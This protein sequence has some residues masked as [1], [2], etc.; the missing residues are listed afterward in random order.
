MRKLVIL[1]GNGMLGREL[2]ALS[3][4][5]GFDVKTFD[6]PTFDISNPSAI[7]D[8]IKGAD[9]IVNCAAYTAVDKAESEPDICRKVNADALLSL[10]EAVRNEGSYL[11]HISTDFVFGDSSGAALKETDVPTPLN[12]YGKTKLEGE[13][14]LASTGCR[15]AVIRVEWTYGRHGNNFIT[16]IIELARKLDCLKVVDDQTGAPTWTFDVSRAILNMLNNSTEGLFH[17]SCRGSASRFEVAS[18]I[19]KELKI[20]KKLV[21]CKSSDFPTP[22]IRPLNSVF[23]CSK[24]DKVLDFA[25]PQWQDSLKSFLAQF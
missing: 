25:R 23:D 20:T 3:V 18:F 22:A 17:F 8:S 2:S 24:I 15:N 7:R 1:G 9:F 13:K 5:R 4:D 14:L 11:L 12:T 19:L 21:P 16:K 10:G 6:L